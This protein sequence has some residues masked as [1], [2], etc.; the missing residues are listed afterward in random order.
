MK[1]FENF[2][3]TIYSLDTNPNNQQLV[4]DILARSTFLREISNNTS[5]AYD[6]QVQD[7]DTAEIVAH[8]VYGDPYKNWII[9]LFNQIVNP[10]YDWPMRMEVLDKF[11]ESKYGTTVEQSRVD[12]HHYE[13]EITK[14][15][16]SG[17]ALLES[18]TTVYVIGEYDLDQRTGN[19]IPNA[20]P[21]VADTSIFVN[22][23]II[24]YNTY[25]LTVTT[26]HKAVSN[27]TY[28]FL[29]NEKRRSIR[30]LQPTYIT[31]VEEELRG[32]MLN[33]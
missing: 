23:E 4:V 18:N 28:E 3:R 17:G 22:S 13:K 29:E 6:Y 21:N 27:Y 32:L 12:I 9:L 20:L 33:D 7:S 15:V 30:L 5:V 25:V 11:I 8:K 2:P 26:S 31:K 14:T 1:Y 10:Y 16:V 19:L 24:N